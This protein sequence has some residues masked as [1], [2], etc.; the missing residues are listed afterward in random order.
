[1]CRQADQL[2]KKDF[3]GCMGIAS[4]R[5]RCDDSAVNDGDHELCWV[6][7]VSDGENALYG[8]VQ[9]AASGVVGVGD[10]F[11]VSC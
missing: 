7:E 2:A 5:Q 8:I 4:L 10:G 1:M 9:P 6:G 11:V 3:D